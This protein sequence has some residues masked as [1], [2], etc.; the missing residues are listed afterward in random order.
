[1]KPSRL[2]NL[3]LFVAV[4]GE[5]LA[6]NP[7]RIGND[8]ALFFVV[9]DFDHWQD[10]P[11]SSA[12]QVRD[13]ERELKDYYGF[14]TE[15]VVNPTRRQ[16]L[17]KLNEYGLRNFG[18]DDQLLVYFSTHG[19]YKEGRIGVLIPKD[20]KLN[21]PTYE[22]TI[23]HPL[24]EDLVSNISCR[25]IT[26]ALDACYSGTFEGEK[27]KPSGQPWEREGD[28]KT[29]T[30]SALQYQSRLYLTSGDKERT[31]VNSQFAAKWLDA[32]QN[33]NHDGVLS[34][35]DLVAVVS[36]ANPI[37]RYGKFK[38]H[39]SRGDFV[40]VN[41]N[42][43]SNSLQ[44]TNDQQHW[45]TIQS[46]F[47]TENLLKHLDLFPNCQHQE[48]L[49]SMGIGQTIVAPDDLPG[50]VFVQGG[51][52]QMGSNDGDTDEKPVHQ[53]TLS[54][55]NMAIHELTFD[56]YD[57]YCDVT[58]TTKPDDKG[59]GRGKRPVIN[60]SW[61]DA[62]AYC[63]WRS[64]Q[65]GLQKAYSISGS[66]VTPN[67]DANGYRLPTEAE[68]EYAARSLG[69][70]ETWAGTNVESEL[71]RFANFYG[72]TE[73]YEFTALVGSLSSNAI[74]LYDMSG[75]VWEWCWD[76]KSHYQPNGQVNPRGIYKGDNRVM[77]GGGWN[78]RPSRVRCSIRD[79]NTPDSKSFNLGFR[80][81]RTVK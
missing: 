55:F 46:D 41:K 31:P 81:V 14:Q 1:M 3:I 9:T 32:L 79:N 72:S 37:P 52:F 50:F 38:A 73:G 35:A 77:R 53:V 80:I 74:G 7:A 20:G 58:G 13:I 63:N 62:V 33:R 18:K 24:L 65:D 45:L 10:F 4:S 22:T 5:L 25:H 75:N 68:W 61:F 48:V 34:H 8:Y 26:L 19:H 40:F 54:D 60:V 21:D 59:W 47:S 27:G 69:K 39:E 12:Q 16:I 11:A 66:I 43:C 51:S 23:M 70:D 29:K 71:Q 64:E 2:L 15:F 30:A 78:S 76:W 57:A 67:W 42:A 36:D 6:Q 44:P 17:D 28:C 56:E 49:N